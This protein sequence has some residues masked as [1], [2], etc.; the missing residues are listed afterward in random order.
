MNAVIRISLIG[1]EFCANHFSVV[2]PEESWSDLVLLNAGAH[3]CWKKKALRVSNS[4]HMTVM[5]R[6]PAK[7]NVEDMTH[8]PLMRAAALS[9]LSSGGIRETERGRVLGTIY[10][11]FSYF[12]ANS[13][14]DLAHRPPI[15]CSTYTSPVVGGD[16]ADTHARMKK[17]LI[18][19]AHSF[20]TTAIIIMASTKFPKSLWKT[21]RCA[22]TQQRTWRRLWNPPLCNPSI[23][24]SHRSGFRHSSVNAQAKWN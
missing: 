18:T 20:K 7:T 15:R 3:R 13:E 5:N 6:V 14:N 10:T 19:R 21:L 24:S 17:H 22:F 4:F 8:F 12:I 1:P 11:T 23:P 9:A 16:E 2:F